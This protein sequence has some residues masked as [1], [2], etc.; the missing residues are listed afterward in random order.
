MASYMPK[1]QGNFDSS[2]HDPNKTFL[3]LVNL[4]NS[5]C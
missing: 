1:D 5:I 2:V 3:F 4:V